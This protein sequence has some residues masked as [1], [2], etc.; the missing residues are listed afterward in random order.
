MAASCA[1]M[2]RCILAKNVLLDIILLQIHIFVFFV[3]QDVQL[4]H[5]MV[6]IRSALL[7]ILAII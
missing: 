7:V 2:P 3:V 4:A 1:I 5:L 6:L